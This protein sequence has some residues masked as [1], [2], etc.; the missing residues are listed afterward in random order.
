MVGPSMSCA[1]DSQPP[2][3]SHCSTTARPYTAFSL[4]RPV[5]KIVVLSCSGT[6]SVPR[7][8]T[9]PKHRKV[10]TGNSSLGTS[11]RRFSLYKATPICLLYRHRNNFSPAPRF[12]NGAAVC[13]KVNVDCKA[14][15]GTHLSRRAQ[16]RA[17]APGLSH[18][19]TLTQ[20]GRNLAA[21]KC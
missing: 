15:T 17:A 13:R 10:R 9:G 20:E 4:H 2:F 18:R 11:P 3:A 19:L 6:L 7:E 16:P 8:Y 21:P 14:Q 5:A 1:T 12:W